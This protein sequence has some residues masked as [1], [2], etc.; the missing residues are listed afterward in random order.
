MEAKAIICDPAADWRASAKSVQFRLRDVVRFPARLLRPTDYPANRARLT[1]ISFW[2]SFRLRA[3][4]GS[5][6]GFKWDRPAALA[7]AAGAFIAEYYNWCEA[8]GTVSDGLRRLDQA[9]SRA[10]R[11]GGNNKASGRGLDQLFQ[12]L[13]SHPGSASLRSR[14]IEVLKCAL[15]FGNLLR[16]FCLYV[17]VLIRSFIDPTKFSH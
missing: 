13:S 10:Y 6:T 5:G 1:S 11:C 2:I 12:L 3:I 8:R 14:R 16:S 17:F 9:L 15:C 4:F 7:E